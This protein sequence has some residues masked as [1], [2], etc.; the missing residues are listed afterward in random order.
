MKLKS[1][2]RKLKAMKII[3]D[4][5]KEKEEN[6]VRNQ[7]FTRILNEQKNTIDTLMDTI[8]QL[9]DNNF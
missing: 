1:Q 6:Q 9:K 5:N 3:N 7:K 4:N 8:Q 2:C